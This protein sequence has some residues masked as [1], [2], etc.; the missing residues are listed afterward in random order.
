M[1]LD[2]RGQ[3]AGC[4][5]TLLKQAPGN[6]KFGEGLGAAGAVVLATARRAHVPLAP[7]LKGV[8]REARLHHQPCRD[9]CEGQ[10]QGC[11]RIE[12]HGVPPLTFDAHVDPR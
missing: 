11:V 2:D 3:H 12:R 10:D 4:T 1:E 7:E 8:L 6:G 9:G 5:S